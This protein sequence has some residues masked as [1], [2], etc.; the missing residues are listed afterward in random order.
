[1]L[2]SYFFSAPISTRV[3]ESNDPAAPTINDLT[4]QDC[5]KNH[6]YA[7]TISSNRGY[8][9]CRSTAYPVNGNSFCR[10]KLPI[11]K[12]KLVTFSVHYYYRLSN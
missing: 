7:A 9:V 8:C 5:V 4:E 1:M 3:Y 12:F 10:K 11:S 6:G 2:F